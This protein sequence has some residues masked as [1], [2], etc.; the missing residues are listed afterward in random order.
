MTTS[1][2]RATEW[3]R[4]LLADLTDWLDAP[5]VAAIGDIRGKMRERLGDQPAFERSN[6]HSTRLGGGLPDAGLRLARPPPR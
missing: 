2:R 5:S 6:W 1:A 4:T 3:L